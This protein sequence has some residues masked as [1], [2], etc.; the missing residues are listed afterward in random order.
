M[1]WLHLSVI[2]GLSGWLIFLLHT[3]PVNSNPLGADH[4]TLEGGGRG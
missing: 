1:Q 3:F 2:Q 4:L